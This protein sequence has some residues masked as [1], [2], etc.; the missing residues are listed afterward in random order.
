MAWR[1]RRAPTQ[2][3]R[4]ATPT[5]R[6]RCSPSFRGRRRNP[7]PGNRVAAAGHQGPQRSAV[8]ARR[9]PRCGAQCP[10]G[11]Q[12]VP[13]FPE[14]RRRMARRR[15]SRASRPAAR[16]R[17]GIQRAPRSPTTGAR[18]ATSCGRS[19]ARSSRMRSTSAFADVDR[20]SQRRSTI[21][22]AYRRPCRRGVCDLRVGWRSDAAARCWQPSPSR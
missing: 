18:T 10:R 5:A 12:H 21:A 6:C 14:P 13:H 4:V 1:L 8:L 7:L 17:Q 11:C 16:S 15:G 3:P 22:L 19:S 9:P 20:P 2:L